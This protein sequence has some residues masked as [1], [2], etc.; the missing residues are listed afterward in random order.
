MEERKFHSR[1]DLLIIISIVVIAAFSFIAYSFVHNNDAD[2]DIFAEISLNGELIKIVPLNED[3]VFSLPQSPAV[4]FEI[5][6]DRIRFKA[7]DCLDQLCVRRGFNS[8]AG[9]WYA[10]LP[11]GVVMRVVSNNTDIDE[12]D[13]IVQ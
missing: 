3:M 12:L 6:Q 7:S 13:M 11:R 9:Q 5:N 10:C 4:Y 8:R 1:S 2:A